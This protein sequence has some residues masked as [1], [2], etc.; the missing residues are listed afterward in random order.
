MLVIGLVG[1]QWIREVPSLFYVKY[2]AAG[3]WQI[4]TFYPA[5]TRVRK[6]PL[7]SSV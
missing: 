7:P 5:D 4:I 6:P 2:L 3:F 1:V